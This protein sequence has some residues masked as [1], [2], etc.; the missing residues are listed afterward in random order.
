MLLQLHPESL[1]ILCSRHD[2]AQINMQVFG[3]RSLAEHEVVG[4]LAAQLAASGDTGA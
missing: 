1:L 4:E 2:H 3:D